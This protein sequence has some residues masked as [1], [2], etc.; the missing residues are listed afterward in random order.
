MRAIV[1]LGDGKRAVLDTNADSCLY[2]DQRGLDPAHRQGTDIFMHLTKGGRKI[3]YKYVWSLYQNDVDYIEV[4]SEE[5]ARKIL[6]EKSQW[7]TEEDIKVI[8]KVFPDFCEET[9]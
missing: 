5:E 3:F 9:A 8:Q 2:A 1:R 7:M 6:E 4:I